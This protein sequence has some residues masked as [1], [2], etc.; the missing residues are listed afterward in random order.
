MQSGNHPSELVSSLEGI[1]GLTDNDDNNDEFDVTSITVNSGTPPFTVTFN[2]EV[3]LITSDNVFEVET[4]GSGLLEVKS[5]KACEGVMSKLI[6]GVEVLKLIASPNPVL[7]NLKIS[8]PKL[9]EDSINTEIHDITGK[10]LFSEQ[11]RVFDSST[12]NV[13]FN[14][15][16]SGVY[17][18]KLNLNKPQIIKIIKK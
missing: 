10:L 13:P 1:F 15:F 5:D 6:D 17:F 9:L 11:I 4:K 8:I 18:V 12:I 16:S 7:N 14:N 3:L 2:Q